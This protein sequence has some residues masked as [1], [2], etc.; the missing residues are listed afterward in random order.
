MVLVVVTKVITT[1]SMILYNECAGYPL[2]I[3]LGIIRDYFKVINMGT[4]I[5]ISIP[6]WAL[7]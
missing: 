3:H 1:R 4:D 5:I 7:H 6:S 2:D